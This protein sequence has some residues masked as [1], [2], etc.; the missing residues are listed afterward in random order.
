MRFTIDMDDELLQRAMKS[1]VT[2]SKSE[3]VRIARLTLVRI[4]NK[5]SLND[6]PLHQNC[7][8]RTRFG[9]PSR[10]KL[11]PS[12]S[13]RNGSPHSLPIAC[14]H[15]RAADKPPD[16]LVMVA[17]RPI[18]PNDLLKVPSKP[19]GPSGASH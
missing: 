10:S 1:A 9:D 3:A 14:T 17:S 18:E 16:A 8:R 4:G 2:N 11:R 5:A 19:Q 15:F 12:S 7:H 6:P 13:F